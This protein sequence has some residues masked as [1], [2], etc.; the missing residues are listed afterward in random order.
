M[1]K[2]LLKTILVLSA[3]ILMCGCFGGK[4]GRRADNGNHTNK[5][6]GKACNMDIQCGVGYKCSEGV[7]TGGIVPEIHGSCIEGNY[8]KKVCSNSGK[9]C[10]VD[11][12]CM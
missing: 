5:V 8:G 1:K 11:T 3:I 7:C 12:D 4:Y 10:W 9:S 6:L 2:N